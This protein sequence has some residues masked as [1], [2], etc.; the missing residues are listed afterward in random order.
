MWIKTRC[1]WH[2]FPVAMPWGSLENY[3]CGHLSRHQDGCLKAPKVRIEY[4]NRFWAPPIFVILFL[5]LI[6]SSYLLP[7]SSAG[8]GFLWSHGWISGLAGRK[9]DSWCGGLQPCIWRRFLGTLVI[10][11]LLA[12]ATSFQ[13]STTTTITHEICASLSTKRRLQL[14]WSLLVGLILLPQIT[15]IF[16]QDSWSISVPKADD[17]ALALND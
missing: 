10:L 4:I 16:G 3:H 15:Q 12:C 17:M 6:K 7:K 1:R 11:I 8:T 13:C 14:A 2:F 9:D 5:I